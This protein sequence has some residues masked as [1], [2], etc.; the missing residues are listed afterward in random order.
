MTLTVLRPDDG[1]MVKLIQYDVVENEEENDGSTM[2]KGT[3]NLNLLVERIE[4]YDRTETNAG[5]EQMIKICYRFGGYIGERVFPAKVLKH[6]CRKNAC[7][8]KER[9]GYGKISLVS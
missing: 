1:V 3:E 5:A 7:P 8:L 9:K 6:P 2:V 4:V